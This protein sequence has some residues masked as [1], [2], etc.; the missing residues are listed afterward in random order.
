MKLNFLLKLNYLTVTI[1]VFA[2]TQVVCGAPLKIPI[3]STIQ[4]SSS[5]LNKNFVD[6][7]TETRLSSPYGARL[8]VRQ[9]DILSIALGIV[10]RPSSLDHKFHSW[11]SLQEPFGWLTIETGW[12]EEKR[13]QAEHLKYNTGLNTIEYDPFELSYHYQNGMIKVYVL[14][15]PAITIIAEPEPVRIHFDRN[16][17]EFNKK[18]WIAKSEYNG[19]TVYCGL[20]FYNQDVNVGDGNSVMADGV[21]ICWAQSLDELAKVASSLSDIKSVVK[22]T[23]KWIETLTRPVQIEGDAML[24]KNFTMA[25]RGYLSMSYPFGGSYAALDEYLNFW[26]RDSG[27]STIWTALSGNGR[28]LASQPPYVMNNPVPV[29]DNGI[30]WLTFQTF[31]RGQEFKCESDGAF[32]ATLAVYAQWKLN[33]DQKHLGQW[34]SVLNSA[35]DFLRENSFD[36]EKQLYMD[37]YVVESPVIRTKESE[38][39]WAETWPED[40]C[41]PVTY[42]SIGQNNIMYAVHLMLA[43]MAEALGKT[44]QCAKHLFFAENLAVA[45]DKYLWKP[46]KGHY[47]W[48]VLQLANGR[49]EELDLDYSCKWYDGSMSTIFNL[50]FFPM[51]PDPQKSFQT[52]DYILN[53][54]YNTFGGEGKNLYFAPNIAQVAHQYVAAG[55]CDKGYFLLDKIH[56]A[57]NKVSW[58]T[59]NNMDALY[60]MKGALCERT[61]A[62]IHLPYPWTSGAYMAAVVSFITSLDFNGLCIMPSAYIKHVNG[63]EFRKAVFA[64]STEGKDGNGDKQSSPESIGIVFDGKPVPH[65]LKIPTALM[66]EG[67]HNVILLNGPKAGPVLKYTPFELCTLKSVTKGIEY[68]MSGYGKAVLRF[69]DY[70]KK[71]MIKVRDKFGK[72]M[73]FDFR[74]SKGG[75]CLSVFGKGSFVVFICDSVANQQ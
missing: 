74:I 11:N 42:S 67:N 61:D 58:N 72:S 48:A 64:I 57:V 12:P 1:C 54:V 44:D 34:Y 56:K 26:V 29:I 25:K 51:S 66:K 3:L 4:A 37:L 73:P 8:R 13:S 14:D 33:A 62:Q 46:Q 17:L 32:F 23:K 28:P 49:T 47:I 53:R 45:I 19:A 36:P 50:T 41:G 65:T 24:V 27:V 68:H 15:R 39:F 35:C 60:Y 22:S 69:N 70:V 2:T 5:L 43:E 59:Q 71:E 16:K 18:Y 9:E 20:V 30:E 52:L 7:P 55:E 63:L 31:P 75:P 6:K 21:S 38:R 10:P 40:P